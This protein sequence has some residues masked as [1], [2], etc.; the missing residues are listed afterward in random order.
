MGGTP[1]LKNWKCIFSCQKDCRKIVECKGNNIFLEGAKGGIVPVLI[2]GF[3]ENDEGNKIF[4]GCFV[5]FYG[6]SNDNENTILPRY[7]KYIVEI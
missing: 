2:K 7:G 4:D 1:K 3:K 5:A 6:D